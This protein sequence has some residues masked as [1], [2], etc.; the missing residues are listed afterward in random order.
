MRGYQ[1]SVPR[2]SVADLDPVAGNYAMEQIEQVLGVKVI[3]SSALRKIQHR[4]TTRLLRALEGTE[5]TEILDQLKPMTISWIL[6][7]KF[8]A[9][10]ASA[11]VHMQFKVGSW[12]LAVG[13]W[14]L[15]VE[16][17]R[18][19]LPADSLKLILPSPIRS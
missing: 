6:F 4:F 3:G 11:A 14:Q 7:Q 10:S 18:F 15:A 9:Y 2:D 8:S 5:R 12:Q 1:V 16:D 17:F 19:K 13:S